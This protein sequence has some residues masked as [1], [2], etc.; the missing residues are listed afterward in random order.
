M[1]RFG[2]K[3]KRGGKRAGL[4]AGAAVVALGIAGGGA[5]SAS[6]ITCGSTILGEGS[7]LQKTSQLSVWG[8][9]FESQCGGGVKLEYKPEGSAAGLKAWDFVPSSP[10]HAIDASRAFVGTDDAPT[11]AQIGNALAA[12]GGSTHVLVIPVAQAA[13]AVPVHPPVGCTITEITNGQLQEVFRGTKKRW[14]QLDTAHGAGCVNAKITRVVR[15]DGS[16]TSY[17]FKHYLSLIN[18][19]PLQCVEGSK[20]WSEIQAVEDFTTNKPNTTW[21]ENG[22][23]GCTSNQLSPVVTS[24]PATGGGALVKKVNTTSGSIGY[25][26]LAD[27]ELNKNVTGTGENPDHN[28]HWLEL[29][30]N[31]IGSNV[32]KAH[33]AQPVDPSGELSNCSA[34]QYAVPAAAQVESGTGVDVDWS[35]VYGSKVGIGGEAYPLC[36]LTWDIAFENYPGTFTSGQITSVKAY[37]AEYVTAEAGQLAL[38]TASQKFYA[39]LPESTRENR[40]VLGAA[41]LSAS[42]IK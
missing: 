25:A 12:A 41:Q 22:V 29:Q 26:A 9:S 24:A 30:N 33:M 31:G 18:N 17:Q 37:L 39:A 21:P 4:L 14:D 13:I 19:T 23:A 42:L 11:S 10:P 40:N 28:T 15:P 20:S 16:G 8:P 7:S 6:A 32:G 3:S 27:V 1:L 5:S 36:T 38:E 34:A 35:Q 2:K